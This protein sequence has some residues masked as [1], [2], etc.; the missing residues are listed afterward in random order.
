LA[1]DA[2]P[3]EVEPFSVDS[4][5]DRHERV[6]PLRLAVSVDSEGKQHERSRH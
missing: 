2:S 1:R 3:L 5:G 6:S 4:E